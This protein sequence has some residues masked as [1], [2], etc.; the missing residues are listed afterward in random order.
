MLQENVFAFDVANFGVSCTCVKGNG[1]HHFVSGRQ[2]S[3]VIKDRQQ[4]THFI[5]IEG[6]NQNLGFLLHIYFQCGVAG[7]ILLLD[8]KAKV[9][10]QAFE[11][12]IDVGGSQF[13]GKKVLN[14]VLDVQSVDFFN[15]SDA[16]VFLY[17]SKK[18]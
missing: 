3:R 14:V 7:D 1:E 2:K 4:R 18:I 5:I 13:F 9:S 15:L 8:C 16:M 10:T 12:I 6:F 11:N 17:I